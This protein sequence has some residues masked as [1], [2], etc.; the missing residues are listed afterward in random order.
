MHHIWQIKQIN[1]IQGHHHVDHHNCFGGKGSG[2]I[3]I[4]VNALA[5]WI[6]KYEYDIPS[7]GS[8]SDDSFGLEFKKNTS[9]YEPYNQHMPVSQTKLLKLWD[10]LGIPHK[11]KKQTSGEI[12]TII[13]IKVNTIHC[14]FLLPQERKAELLQHLKDFM[15]NITSLISFVIMFVFLCFLLNVLLHNHAS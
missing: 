8:Y 6:T 12:L 11:E 15:L 2:S 4:S 13:R 10:V 14:T 9:F 7:L 3:F 5:T 1:T